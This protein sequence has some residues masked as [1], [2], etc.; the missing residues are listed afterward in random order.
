[1]L[2]RSPAKGGHLSLMQFVVIASD[3]NRIIAR[4]MECGQ[5]EVI[6][7]KPPSNAIFNLYFKKK[8]K[9]YLQFTI[10]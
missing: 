3:L 8:K 10:C 9:C 1:M 6:K 2:V 5:L 7:D 4:V